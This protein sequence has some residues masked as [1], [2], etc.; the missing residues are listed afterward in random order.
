MFLE[1]TVIFQ[2]LSGRV[3]VNLVDGIFVDVIEPMK[4]YGET[5][6]K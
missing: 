5:T 4:I 3:D 6:E 1:E 2:P